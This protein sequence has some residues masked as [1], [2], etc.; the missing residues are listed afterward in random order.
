MPR[1]VSIDETVDGE[2]VVEQFADH[3]IIEAA[4]GLTLP[5]RE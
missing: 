4:V 3:R 2:P 1:F 5:R